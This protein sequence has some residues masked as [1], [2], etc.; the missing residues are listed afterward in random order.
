[1]ALQKRGEI[2]MGLDQWIL[3][4]SDREEEPQIIDGEF[5]CKEVL[6]LR[7]EEWLH[8]KIIKIGEDKLGKSYE[9]LNCV[10]IPLTKE[11]LT[12]ILEDSKECVHS[13]SQFV[14]NEKF[15]TGVL[16][17]SDW[18]FDLCLNGMKIFN[19]T[20]GSALRSK[21]ECYWYFAWW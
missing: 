8:N 11:E 2:I 6:Q 10:F 15:N 12:E 5:N 9:D 19:K 20:M 16:W 13:K 3:R 18:D 1:M 4:T 21:D 7:K 17:Y 14:V